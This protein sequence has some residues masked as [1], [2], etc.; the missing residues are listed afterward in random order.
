[1]NAARYLLN[2][3]SPRGAFPELECNYLEAMYNSSGVQGYKGYRDYVATKSAMMLLESTVASIMETVNLIETSDLTPE[4]AL[5]STINRFGPWMKQSAEDVKKK[6]QACYDNASSTVDG[7]RATAVTRIFGATTDKQ[8]R[9][10]RLHDTLKSIYNWNNWVAAA[11]NEYDHVCYFDYRC[12]NKVYCHY[13]KAYGLQVV[14]AEVAAST[15]API[16]SFVNQPRWDYWTSYGEMCTAHVRDNI[17]EAGC[18]G[19]SIVSRTR[20]DMKFK[21]DRDELWEVHYGHDQ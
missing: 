14:V 11:A 5:E 6:V 19:G 20:Q 3:L 7:N 13:E 17:A 21:L 16:Q 8:T 18:G 12:D 4:E 2:G 1:M 9:V 10:D 15:K